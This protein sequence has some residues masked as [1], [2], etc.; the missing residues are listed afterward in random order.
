MKCV[1]MVGRFENTRL[2]TL[3]HPDEHVHHNQPLCPQ[4]C[5]RGRVAPLHS[6]LQLQV[7]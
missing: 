2:M 3:Q 1:V 4:G 5:L 7:V 6:E